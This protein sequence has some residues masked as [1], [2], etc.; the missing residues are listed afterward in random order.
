MGKFRLQLLQLSHLPVSGFFVSLWQAFHRQRSTLTQCL[1]GSKDGLYEQATAYPANEL[2]DAFVSALA[3]LVLAQGFLAAQNQG[4]MHSFH[5]GVTLKLIQY[6]GGQAGILANTAIKID[7]GF[8]FFQLDAGA[9]D[10]FDFVVHK[11]LGH[12]VSLLKKTEGTQPP[13]EHVDSPAMV[14][15]WMPT[16]LAQERPTAKLKACIPT[17][18]RNQIML[19]SGHILR[20]T[21][22]EVDEFR[23][24]GIDVHGVQTQDGLEQAL[25]DWSSLLSQERPDLLEKI[26]LEMAKERG[27][28]PPAKLFVQPRAV[29]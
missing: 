19:R 6:L 10:S 15:V 5:D 20:F 13:R 29:E 14:D 17:R 28:K 3:C 26:A 23:S 22:R 16:R 11:L 9:F 7:P 21:P 8:F 1:P 25:E 4:Q 27:L 24:L 2:T 18:S 12:G